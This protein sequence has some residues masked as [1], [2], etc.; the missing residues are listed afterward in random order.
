MRTESLLRNFI[1]SM[2]LAIVG[3]PLHAQADTTYNP[4][5]EIVF[6]DKR[7]R[8]YNNW[9]SGGAG[10]A[11]H[12]NNPRTQL[13][14]GISFNFHIQQYYFRVGGMFSGDRFGSWNNYQGHLGYIIKRLENEKRNLAFIAGLS[15]STGYRFLYAGH[16]DTPNPYGK[17]GA[18]LEC[19]YIRKLNYDFGIGSALFAD[20]NDLN[21]II[22][23]RIDVYFSGAYRG[24]VRG[25]E[26]K[27]NI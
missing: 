14:L 22:G 4:K 18:Y 26:P 17:P 5:K 11:W 21:Q 25:K 12:S 27:K 3:L 16:Y 13:A 8:V 24:Y 15:Y 10:P 2:L 19:Q 20:I 7:F 9:I 23:L 1:L 6:K